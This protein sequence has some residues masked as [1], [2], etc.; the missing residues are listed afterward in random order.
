M[1][2]QYSRLRVFVFAATSL[3]YSAGSAAQ[4]TPHDAIAQMRK[5][6]NMGNTLEPPYESGWN[7]PNAKEYYFDLYKEAGFNTVRI[8]VRWDKHTGT[9]PPYSIDESWLNRVEQVL[10]W[11]LERDLWIIV[12]SHHDDWIKDNYEIP[13]NRDRFDSI[14][15]QL[16]GRLAGKSEKLIFEIL[17]EPYGLTKIQNDE[18]HARV[19]SI[20]RQTNP[21]RLVIFQG[22]NWGGSSELISAALP[23]DDYLIG[24]FHTY[25][26][27]TFGLLGQGKWGSLSDI[28]IIRNKFAEVKIWSDTN[29]IP[30]LLGEFG[31]IRVTK[32]M[33]E[34][35]T[36]K[37]T[38]YN[39]RM[40]H[41][42]TYVEQAH[43][44]GFCFCAWDDGGDFRI[45]ER[46]VKKWPEVKDI[47][48]H[49]NPGSPGYPV[50]ELY[51]DT[52]IL[53][54]WFRRVTDCDRLL[55]QRSI[56]NSAFSNI[57]TISPDSSRYFDENLAQ[58]RYYTYRVIA[59][60]DS[61]EDNY[62]CPVR[63]FL[64][65]YVPKVRLPF[66]G[67]PL[68][69]PGIIEAEDF[70][71]GGE[72]LTYHDSDDANIAGAYRSGVGVDI[73][74][75]LGDGYHIGNALPGEWLEYTVDVKYADTFLVK[76]HTAAPVAGGTYRLRVGELETE[77]MEAP[78]SYSWLETDTATTTMI[79]SEGIQFMRF[80]ILSFPQFNIDKIE[81]SGLSET[82]DVNTPTGPH[83]GQP[84]ALVAFQNQNMDLV[85]R[86][87]RPVTPATIL[88]YNST[89]ALLFR[90]NGNSQNLVVPASVLEQGINIIHT[91]LGDR[92]IRKKVF[93]HK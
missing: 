42:Q 3:L 86:S 45:L 73:Y 47:L 8:P 63:I 52:T 12:N 51:Q 19:L 5:G 54:S 46:Q 2:R 87:G 90:H 79:L 77:L 84:D 72:D 15:T 22:H 39:S 66:H 57:D 68:P 38:D 1:R 17:N 28:Q 31:A 53:L 32:D 20:I 61:G 30:V 75:R 91:D 26:P 27:Y 59:D 49:G 67:E 65:K 7:N 80:S 6:I 50:A 58:E 82:T 23:D 44:N 37:Y 36:G 29:N 21:T 64:P 71:D 10:D 33:D 11:G 48:I 81:F 18:M 9:T 60:Y 89:G 55:V 70:D 56:G 85:I 76:V 69:I 78:N 62:S 13:S 25:D 74:D 83:A 24:S 14:W 34:N 93:I 40:K 92:V 88:I 35:L 41:Y 16:S 4:V 43:M